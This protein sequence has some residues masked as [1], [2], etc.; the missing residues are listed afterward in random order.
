M[1]Q[2]LVAIVGPTA[3]G[4]T[5]LSLE[6]ARQLN[7]E[8]LSCDSMQIYRGMDIGT[9]KATAEEQQQAVHHLLDIVDPAAPFSVADYQRQA[10]A[11]IQEVA[12][13][14]KLPVLVGGTGLFY[15]AVADCY[16]FAPEMK[17]AGLREKWRK[18]YEEKGQ[19]YLV[20]CLERLDPAY[21]KKIGAH[22][23]KRMLHALEVTEA[24][25]QPFSE[26]MRKKE[27]TWQLAVIG[28]YMPRAMLY[29]RINLRVEQMIQA[30]LLKEVAALQA[31]G[32]TAKHQSMQAIGYKQALACLQGEITREQMMEE[33]QRESRKYAKRQYTWFKK[34]ERIFW[35]NTGSGLNRC[36][37][38]AMMREYIEKTIENAYNNK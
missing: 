25:G 3:V 35:I 22:D 2:P 23:V 20:E 1:K 21:L 29:E 31:A 36:Q 12:G 34:D 26:R 14:G 17:S 6:L 7:G 37:I 11:V 24:T 33:I 19:E 5:G 13:R 38:V 10:Y 28:L 15:Q 9:A 8:I 16:D 27:D 30:G 32:L 4:K 18:L